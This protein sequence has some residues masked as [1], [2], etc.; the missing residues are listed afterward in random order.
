[1]RKVKNVK[2]I[3]LFINNK[4]VCDED[5]LKL[6]P[7]SIFNTEFH[8]NA[9]LN[10]IDILVDLNMLTELNSSNRNIYFN[11]IAFKIP[12]GRINTAVIK[13]LEN[14]DVRIISSQLCFKQITQKDNIEILNNYIGI[15]LGR[16][17]VVLKYIIN[18]IFRFANLLYITRKKDKVRN[19]VKAW[20][21]VSYRIHGYNRFCESLVLIYPFPYS[22]KRQIKFIFQLILNKNKFGFGFV[23]YSFRK[24]IILI[25]NTNISN[26]IDFEIDGQN[27][28]AKY[29]TRR[30]K[31]LEKIYTEDD[32]TPSIIEFNLYFEKLNIEIISTSHGVN[33]QVP[34]VSATRFEYLT[35]RQKN[36]YSK[37]SDLRIKFKKQKLHS[38][39]PNVK[40]ND[41]K[42]YVYIIIH[43]NFK[44]SG[45]YYEDNL[46]LTM[47]SSLLDLQINNLFIKYHPNSKEA[48]YKDLTIVE[49]SDLDILVN[50]MNIIFL[51]INSTSFFTYG[52]YGVFLFVHDE[53]YD[54]VDIFGCDITKIEIQHLNSL[55]SFT[56]HFNWHELYTKQIQ[57][58]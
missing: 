46:Q 42:K 51:T 49:D 43:S 16:V 19:I 39:V 48:K 57:S 10:L 31:N 6:V 14:Q 53:N 56:N 18:F 34:V 15:D 58:L 41:F 54:P 23:N 55:L 45:M 17:N 38:K 20:V 33:Q 9:V 2:Y 28:S 26:Y 50:S 4:I 47:I 44:E 11:F 22:L 25:F 12:T 7:N 5:I 32:Y 52:Y 37:Y 3:S 13:L 1:M 21:E 27:R 29:I 24:L 30:Y 8:F 35:T 40:I 36:I